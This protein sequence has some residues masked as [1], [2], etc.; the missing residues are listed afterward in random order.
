MKNLEMMAS[1]VLDVIVVDIPDRLGRGDAIAQCE[2]LAKK[3]S[4][5]FIYTVS[6]RN[7]SHNLRIVPVFET[8]RQ[9]R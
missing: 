3:Q 4:G 9:R 7:N 5:S 6:C 2:M 1:G 8:R